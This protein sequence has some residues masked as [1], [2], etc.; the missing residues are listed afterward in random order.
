MCCQTL[1]TAGTAYYSESARRLPANCSESARRLPEKRSESAR[2]VHG[3]CSA[4]KE[5][6][7]GD[8]SAQSDV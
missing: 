3:K 8:R 1:G 2:K 7:S 6:G 4:L 5:D